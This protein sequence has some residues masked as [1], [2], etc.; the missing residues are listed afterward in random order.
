MYIYNRENLPEPVFQG[1]E[2]WINLYYAAWETTFNNVECVQKEGW[3]PQ[4]TCM[5]GVGVVWQWDSCF[6]TF[7]TNYSNGTLNAFNNLD[8]LYRLRDRETG[9]MAMTYS[10]A[11]EKET[12]PG[13]INPPLMAWAEWE[14]YRVTGDKAALKRFS[15]RWREYTALSRK[16]AAAATDCIGLRIPAPRVWMLCSKRLFADAVAN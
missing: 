15:Q 10:I 6:M 2:D 12:Y 8:N 13:R 14:H 9:F 4:L 16:T 3:K 7:I 11:T 1:H 5:P